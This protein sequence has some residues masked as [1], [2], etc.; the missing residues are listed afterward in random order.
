MQEID[1]FQVKSLAWASKVLQLMIQNRLT[2]THQRCPKCEAKGSVLFRLSQPDG[3]LKGV[4]GAD[5]CDF[6]VEG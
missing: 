3:G 4:C 2:T 5:E 6:S 1:E